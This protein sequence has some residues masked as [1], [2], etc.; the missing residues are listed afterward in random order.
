M[1]FVLDCMTVQFIVISFRIFFYSL[2]GQIGEF[3]IQIHP[4]EDPVLGKPWETGLLY[5]YQISTLCIKLMVRDSMACDTSISAG[6]YLHF[7]ADKEAVCI[8]GYVL[9]MKILH[10]LAAVYNK[11]IIAITINGNNKNRKLL[12]TINRDLQ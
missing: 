3:F 1:I 4:T 5:D 11:W 12:R 9:I 10:H 8:K 2:V 6:C 7:E